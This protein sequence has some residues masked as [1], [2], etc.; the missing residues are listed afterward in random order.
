MEKLK[1]DIG[2]SV[3]DL[4]SYV[5]DFELKVKLYKSLFKGKGIDF[6]GYRDYA[7]GDDASVI[8]WK[9]SKRSNSI[10][11]K[12]YVEEKNAKVTFAIDVSKNML[13]GSTSKLKAEYNAEVVASLTYL[14]LKSGYKV[15][16]ILFGD[17]IVNYFEPSKKMDQFY[18]I[19]DYLTNPENYSGRAKY[20]KMADYVLNNTAKS[21]AI[22]LVSDFIDFDKNIE[23]KL[24][25]LSNNTEILALMIRDPLDNSLPNYNGEI[26][27]E[28][29]SR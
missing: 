1:A 10:L 24:G 28:D 29:Q 12:Q 22:I 4:Q 21:D 6:D 16:F 15:G 27:F 9:A 20:D 26:V 19:I 23:N 3:A 11:V 14:M 2:N 13:A 25:L 17:E 5:K 18:L 7:P 8:D